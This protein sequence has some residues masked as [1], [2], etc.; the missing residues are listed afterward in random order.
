M[1][2][3]DDTFLSAYLDGQ[4]DSE[5][6]HLVE[7][8]LVSK[9]E[10]AEKLRTLTSLRDLVA[11][12]NRDFSIDVAARVMGR[13]RMRRGARSRVLPRPVW[14]RMVYSSPRAA[15]AAGIAAGLLL[16]VT[17]AAPL[18]INGSHTGAF[19]T[20]AKPGSTPDSQR[21][22]L[23]AGSASR[24]EAG[25][26]NA[27]GPGTAIE[28]ARDGSR[29]ST[30]G[31]IDR[32]EHAAASQRVRVSDKARAHTLEHYRQLLD[33]PNQRRL[34]RITDGGDGKALQQVASVLEST[35]RFGFYKITIA[36]GIVIDPRHPEEA[37]VYAALVNA[38]SFDTLRDRLAQALPDAVNESPVDPAVVTQLAD[39]GQV[40][41]FRSAPFGDVLIPREGLALQNPPNAGRDEEPGGD[42]VNPPPSKQPT[43]EQ[44]RSA[45]IGEEIARRLT[46]GAGAAR[47]PADALESGSA[48]AAKAR[49]DKHGAPT[50]IAARA[51]GVQTPSGPAAP[52]GQRETPEE[53]FVVLVWVARSHH[54]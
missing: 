24:R 3:D 30:S 6:R 53:T 15:L 2:R 17:L 54:G 49:I 35:T 52:S 27:A 51:P 18:L 25:K 44:E 7:S 8:A 14:L 34:F 23:A 37:T 12:L 11:S 46:S 21:D 22:E 9:P 20:L 45:P 29:E 10:L 28:A 26:L 41:A 40:R 31:V 36:Q 1:N 39:I 19:R 13:V 32:G 38:K 48:R 33:N 16:A 42:E 5:E 47:A 4:L 50:A 43:I